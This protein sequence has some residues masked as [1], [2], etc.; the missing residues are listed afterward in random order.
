MES[1]NNTICNDQIV[2][3]V[4]LPLAEP[5]EANAIKT[6]ARLTTTNRQTNTG[7]LNNR[8]PLT[9]SHNS[10]EC[11][12]ST[13]NKLSPDNQSTIIL[14]QFSIMAEELKNFIKQV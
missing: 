10:N 8:Q 11:N 4:Q 13:N 3:M 1:H 12:A 6:F 2:N 9:S 14:H 5:N 7:Q